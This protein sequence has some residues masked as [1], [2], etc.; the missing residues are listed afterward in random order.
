M[1]CFDFTVT[2]IPG[3]NSVI[4]DALSRAPLMEPDSH[5]EFFQEEVKAYVD[6]VVEG[7]SAMER[8]LEEIRITQENDPIYQEVHVL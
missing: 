5:D 3:K 2:Y 6:A 8:R 4:A 7:L 1:L